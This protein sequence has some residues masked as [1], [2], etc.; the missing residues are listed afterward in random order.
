MDGHCHIGSVRWDNSII[1]LQAAQEGWLA[2]QAQGCPWYPG[3]HSLDCPLLW[4]QKL[5]LA[6]SVGRVSA[7][8][9]ALAGPV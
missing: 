7:P 5:G 6:Q 9:A 8:E 1:E 4:P 3:P 2:G